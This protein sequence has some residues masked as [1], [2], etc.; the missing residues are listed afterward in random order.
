MLTGM[1]L[2]FAVLV[3]APLLFADPTSHLNWVMNAMN[4][5]LTGAAWVMADSL[6]GRSMWR[7][8]G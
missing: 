5:C 2:V 8:G 7:I 3:H 1:F 6:R 4:L